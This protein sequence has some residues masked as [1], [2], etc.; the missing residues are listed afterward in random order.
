[1]TGVRR[2]AV[3]SAA[4]GSSFVGVR[5]LLQG[6][7]ER[8]PNQHA[9]ETSSAY[10]ES[11]TRILILGA[12]FGGLMTALELDRRPGPSPGASVLLVDRGNT[13]LF[14]PLLWTVAAGR[15]G[16][17]DAAV[18]IRAFQRGRRFHVLHAEVEAIDLEQR[19]VHTSAGSRP[20]DTLVLGLGSETAVPDIPG[21]RDHALQFHGTADALELRNHVIDALE[22]AHQC[23]DPADRQAWLT[24][25]VCGGGDTGCELAAVVQDYVTKGLLKQYPWLADTPPRVIVLE[26]MERLM[27]FSSPA[28]SSAT[29][30]LLRKQGIEV[31]AETA[32]EEVTDRAVKT[33]HGEM[34]THTVFWAAGTTAPDVIRQL[35]V[36]HERNGAL[37]VDHH[38][39]V[40]GRPE[41]YVIG[42]AA[43][44]NDP[45]THA[46]VPPTAQ[47]AEQEG[48]YVAGAIAAM[49]AGRPSPQPFRFSSHGHLTLL[50]AHNG[51]SEIGSV[52]LTGFPAWFIWHAYYLMRIRSWRNRVH[53]ATD[54][55]LAAMFGR[56]TGQLRLDR[57]AR[58]RRVR[59]PA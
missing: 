24:F 44:I 36:E 22:I 14:Y 16:P 51:V 10:D 13:Q 52:I 23:E 59:Q 28:V 15:A 19:I 8:R 42:D 37:I 27:P 55:L 5:T 46:A 40:P 34:P 12:G 9:S 56:E 20:Y 39:R 17:T 26:R 57:N 49:L 30:R 41:V 54:W 29:T 18:P 31:R 21:L 3:C 50:G 38:L 4:A 47:A 25:V 45:V 2:A 43:W 33:E 6:I 1:M 11:S 32:V 53:L 35:P 7:R 48:R 58:P